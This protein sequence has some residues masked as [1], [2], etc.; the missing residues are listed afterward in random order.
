MN[1]KTGL[2]EKDG[3]VSKGTTDAVVAGCTQGTGDI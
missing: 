3:W 1:E 2:I